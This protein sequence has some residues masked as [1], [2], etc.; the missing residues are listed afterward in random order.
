MSNHPPTPH[1]YRRAGVLLLLAVLLAL[2]LVYLY[3]QSGPL[4]LDTGEGAATIHFEAERG[5]LVFYGQ[6]AL[7]RWDVQQIN[8]VNI[9]GRNTTGTDSRELCSLGN[10]PYLEVTL[11]DNSTRTY[12]LDIEPLY[13]NPLV[14]A[15]TVAMLAA[16]TGALYFAFGPRGLLLALTILV[17]APVLRR[18]A[19]LGGNFIDHILVAG[20]AQ[21]AGNLDVLPPH[22]LFHILILLLVRLLP[23]LSF[24][25]AGFLVAMGAYILCAQAV[26]TLLRWLALTSSPDE[27]G[28]I[29]TAIPQPPSPSTEK[30]EQDSAALEDSLRV[31]RSLPEGG[32]EGFREGFSGF[33]LVAV[34]MGLL[35]AAPITGFTPRLNP[36]GQTLPIYTSSY[37]SPTL[38]LMRPFAVLVFLALLRVWAGRP[39]GWAWWAAGLALF[40]V[41]AT[42][43]KPSYTTAILPAAAL[44]MAYSFV[45][46]FRTN[47][48]LLIGSF[49]LPAVLVLG[50]QYLHLYGSAPQPGSYEAMVYGTAQPKLTFSPFELYLVWWKMPWIQLIL[51]FLLSIA[52]PAAVYLAYWPASRRSFA[53]NLAWLAFG[54][55]A[56]IAYLFIEVPMQANAN[57]VWGAQVTLFVLFAASAGFLLR[58]NRDVIFR[59]AAR[60]D[61]RLA[62]CGLV[63]AAHVASFL[64]R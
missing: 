57:V 48:A 32:G 44:V 51:E 15:L 1:S 23:G 21:Q 10:K 33:I 5:R 59:R 19:N 43:A 63:F 50:W 27:N 6:C 20:I 34:T 31:V 55:G 11:R 26:Y 56:G 12:T 13:T 42:L 62:L 2:P 53:L 47:R 24:E 18:E 3:T 7:L 25:A 61:W 64:L 8:A 41:L 39:R 17:F 58:Q 22:F 52:F 46:A 4:V 40:T 29:R 54:A 30:G 49:V 14:L 35:L 38:D 16:L 45:R 36:T 9:Y 28:A 60:A 37:Y